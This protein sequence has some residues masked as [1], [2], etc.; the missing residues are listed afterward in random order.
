MTDRDDATEDTPPT[1]S[2][3]P[4]QVAHQPFVRRQAQ[5]GRPPSQIFQVGPL[6]KA[7]PLP[8]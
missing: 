1:P 2:P 8:P 4:S 3:I 7:T 6:P 5:W